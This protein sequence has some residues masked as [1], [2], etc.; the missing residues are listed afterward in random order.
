MEEER[1]KGA[2]ERKEREMEGSSDRS[3]W[4]RKIWRI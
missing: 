2:K 3:E 4:S 1:R